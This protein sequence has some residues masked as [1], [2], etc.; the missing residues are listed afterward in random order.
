VLL[1]FPILIANRRRGLAGLQRAYP[2]HAV[3]DLTSRSANLAFQR[4]SPFFPHGGIPVPFSGL[5]SQSVEGVW[6][7]LKVFDLVGG[8]REE[9]D[10]TC[11][12]NTTQKGLKRTLRRRGRVRCVGHYCIESGV[13]LRYLEARREIYLPAYNFV[14]EHRL[15]GELQALAEA[16]RQSPLVLLDY[17]TNADVSDFRTPLS[18]AALVRDRLISVFGPD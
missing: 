11:F 6:Q 16:A 7:G 3:H 13:L 12:A 9:I 18:H 8:D 2:G 1:L 15:E 5:F 4:F 14:L 10:T 17:S